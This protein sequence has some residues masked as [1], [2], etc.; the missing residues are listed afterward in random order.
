MF[1]FTGIMAHAAYLDVPP[2]RWVWA[3]DLY[4]S[5]TP[6]LQ[7]PHAAERIAVYTRLMYGFWV[8]RFARMIYEIPRGGDQRLT[9][10][11]DGWLDTVR[12][13]Y[14]RYVQLAHDA[15]SG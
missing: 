4:L 6:A 7:R 9:P 10:Y 3:R 2:E 11:P 12:G 14:Q 13:R 5:L 8:A 1:E 15:L